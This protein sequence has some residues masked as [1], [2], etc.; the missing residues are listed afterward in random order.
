MTN[1]IA[2]VAAHERVVEDVTSTEQ[3]CPK[4]VDKRR[5]ALLRFAA[6]ITALTVIGHL[7]LG[8]EQAPIVPIVTAVA[9]YAVHL[10]LET[11]DAWAF[12]RPPEYAG[13]RTELFYFLLPAHI[14]AL[15]CAMLIYT[16]TVWPFLFAVTVAAASKYVFRVRVKGRLKHYLN[17]SNA[18]IAVVLLLIPLVGFT[19]PYMFLNNTGDV[20]DVLIPL[21]V[22]TAG[23]ML[24]GKLT[25]KMPL[26]AAWVGGF[27]LQGLV[28][29]IWFD[30]VF[31]SVIGSMTGVAFVLFTN[32]M[33]TDPGTTPVST[34][35][36]VVFGLTVAGVYGL[37]IILQVAYAIFFALV[38]TCAIRG[39]VLYLSP[40]LPRWRPSDDVAAVA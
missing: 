13:G 15:A 30:D 4:P 26:I 14:A 37:L 6:S 29:A 33:I 36:Q 21:G 40:R 19:P 7:L 18:G 27:V 1:R 3:L 38:I 9:S 32:Y 35:G 22:L 17:P 10:L 24:N 25:G 12:R 23:T 34:R 39:L 28:R 8:F 31:L 5:K 20:L 2:S 11:V 16:S